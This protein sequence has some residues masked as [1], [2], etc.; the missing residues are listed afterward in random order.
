[1][2]EITRLKLIIMAF[3]TGYLL[4]RTVKSVMAGGTGGVGFIVLAVV[5]KHGTGT[6]SQ[7]E[8]VS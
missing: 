2:F 6:A 5:E 3:L 7:I 4:S 1:M 8:P